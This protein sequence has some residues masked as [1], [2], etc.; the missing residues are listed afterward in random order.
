MA[1]PVPATR[2]AGSR[3]VELLGGWGVGDAR[4]V[5][6]GRRTRP[7]FMVARPMT[8]TGNWVPT[9]VGHHCE[10]SARTGRRDRFPRRVIGIS[11]SILGKAAGRGRWALFCGENGSTRGGIDVTR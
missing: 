10:F 6:S 9:R 3:Q 1:R 5:R 8:N 11:R 2:A 7:E 4:T